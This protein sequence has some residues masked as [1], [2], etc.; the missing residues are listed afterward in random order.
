MV[1]AKPRSPEKPHVRPENNILKDPLTSSFLTRIIVSGGLG[2][3]S[4][5]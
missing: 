2:F 1:V 5:Q 3:C 4:N